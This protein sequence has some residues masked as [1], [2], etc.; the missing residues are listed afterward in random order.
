MEGPFGIAG[1][2]RRGAESE[3]LLTLLTE[4]TAERVRFS[5]RLNEHDVDDVKQDIYLHVIGNWKHWNSE[6]CSAGAALRVMVGQGCSR[7][8]AK[9]KPKGDLR[10]VLATDTASDQGQDFLNWVPAIACD[11]ITWNPHKG[12]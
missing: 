6:K 12:E 7:A 8:V 3:C 4:S 1:R 5:Y 11:G 2:T 9:L 10:I